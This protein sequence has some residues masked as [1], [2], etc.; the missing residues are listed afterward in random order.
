MVVDFNGRTRSVDEPLP[1]Q[2]TREGDGLC[3]L[4]VD[5]DDC[6]FRMLEPH[7]IAAAMAFAPGYIMLGNKREK[8]RLAGNAVT[9]PAARDLIAAV[10]E[11]LA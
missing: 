10:A 5:V 9:P 11:S 4:E 7:E 6:Y 8:V 3:T 1:T 2:T